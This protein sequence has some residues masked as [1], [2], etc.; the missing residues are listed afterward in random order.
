[1]SETGRR[2]CVSCKVF[3]FQPL[4]VMVRRADGL[5]GVATRGPL[6][7][8]VPVHGIA[9][10]KG[11]ACCFLAMRG[12]LIDI[13]RLRIHVRTRSAKRFAIGGCR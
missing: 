4:A 5:S 1:M 11:E 3:V 9:C 10:M 7:S 2:P 8:L 6:P 12:K 13:V